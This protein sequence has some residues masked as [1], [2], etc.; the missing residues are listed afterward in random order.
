MRKIALDR[1]PDDLEVHLEVPVRDGVAHLVS[2]RQRQ[3][4]VR[5]SEI[6]VLLLDVVAGLADDFQVLDDGV[7]HQRIAHEFRVVHPLRIT[8]DPLD[9]F[10]DMRG[11]SFK[12][13]ERP[14]IPGA[15]LPVPRWPENCPAARWA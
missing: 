7:L 15:L 1:P 6:G 9:R 10:A 8:I 3:F 2:G 5:G 12:R 13:P 11:S 4:R 14:V